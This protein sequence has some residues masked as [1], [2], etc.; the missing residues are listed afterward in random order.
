M[1][2]KS[3]QFC[4]IATSPS[5]QAWLYNYNSALYKQF[6]DKLTTSTGCTKNREIMLSVLDQIGL[7]GGTDSLTE[8]LTKNYPHVIDNSGQSVTTATFGPSTGG[9]F[10]GYKPGILTYPR[11]VIITGGDVAA[12]ANEFVADKFQSDVIIVDGKAYIEYLTVD[13]KDIASQINP[14]KWQIA[15]YRA[16][17]NG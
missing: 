11:R 3:E 8:F 4:A 13:D 9:L 5:W 16:R 15:A 17:Q 2:I 12:K 1:R 14:T 10:V 6:I 7:M